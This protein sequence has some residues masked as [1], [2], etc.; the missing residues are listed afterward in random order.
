MDK[1]VR[2]NDASSLSA[3]VIHLASLGCDGLGPER[4]IASNRSAVY[5]PVLEFLR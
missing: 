5:S 1:R 4:A 2:N 3:S